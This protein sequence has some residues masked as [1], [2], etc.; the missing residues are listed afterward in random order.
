[1]I[2]IQGIANVSK[3]S[4]QPVERVY[5][6]EYSKATRLYRVQ[7]IEC[8][9]RAIVDLFFVESLRSGLDRIDGACSGYLVSWII[10]PA[11]VIES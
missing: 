3:N 11:F 6:I 10:Q 8:G 4:T 1:M 2:T 5:L 9:T 7:G